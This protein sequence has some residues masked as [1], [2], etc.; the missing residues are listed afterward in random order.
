MTKPIA[1]V[2]LGLVLCGCQPVRPPQVS[3]PATAF[4]ETMR[5]DSVRTLSNGVI[6]VAVSAK[7]GRIIYFAFANRGN[8]LWADP[9][10]GNAKP[11][12]WQNWGG[13]KVWIWPQSEFEQRMGRGWPPPGDPPSTP[14]IITD[15][16]DGGITMTSPIIPEYGVRL[17]RTISLAPGQ[18]MMTVT[19]RFHVIDDAKVTGIGLWNVTQIPAPK[20]IVAQ[21]I[22]PRTPLGTVRETFP[23]PLNDGKPAWPPPQPSL[24]ALGE[25][26][27]T[28]PTS[29]N[30][31]IGID[32]D[33]FRVQSGDTF[34]TQKA[35]F[36]PTTGELE[37]SERAQLYTDPASPKT[38]PYVELEFITPKWTAEDA[39]NGELKVTWTLWKPDR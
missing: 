29:G 31:K 8:L 4:V 27:L 34:L 30:A 37:P 26:I 11:G 14:Y 9:D 1:T 38:G 6:D 12:D 5:D 21:P 28:R 25:V 17:V 36:T 20:E 35:E 19:N 13:D 39:K 24:T 23:K 22:Y 3:A 16:L 7:T 10:A 18:P 2:V 15:E 32:A 33:R